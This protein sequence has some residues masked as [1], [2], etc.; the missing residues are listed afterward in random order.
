MP[1]VIRVR[2]DGDDI[3]ISFERKKKVPI[4]KLDQDRQIVFGWANVCVRCSGE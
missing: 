2:Q 4:A 3:L 1:P